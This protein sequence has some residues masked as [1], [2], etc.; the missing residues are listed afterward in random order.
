[1]AA[2]GT[3]DSEWLR[4]L[5]L[6]AEQTLDPTTYR[7]IAQG[8]RE[9]LVAATATAAWRRWRV[10]PESLTA[11]SIATL[12]QEFL[13]TRFASPCAVAPTT[14]QRAVYPEGEVAM[15]HGCRSAGVPMVVS[16]NASAPFEEI[17]ATGVEWWLQAYLPQQRELAEPMV[18]QARACAAK[19]VVLTVDTP[20]V[21][22]KYDGGAMWSAVPSE[23]LRHN[24]GAA[25]QAP[26]A[27]DLGPGDIGWLHRVS[28]LPVVV[29]GVLSPAAARRAIDA[30]AAAIWVSNH[31]G[32]QF[33]RAVATAD[34]L[35]T[36]RDVVPA[37]V[38]L[39]VDGGIS[40]GLD[41]TTALAL[42]ADT[43]FVG[44]LALYALADGGAT[45]VERALRTI[46]T[47]VAESML[48]C[49]VSDVRGARSLTVLRDWSADR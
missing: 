11:V 44:R 7:Y 31:G 28:G 47:E 34:A 46:G 20:V 26:K 25:A 4:D 29:K 18:E 1:M 16:S 48:L 37:D 40:S 38:P 9:G 8:A 27:S 5:A 35:S 2:V 23:W 17:A 6:A 13:G 19:A 10:V 21:G 41:V 43:C 36:I 49:G 15:A 30:G 14:L 22:T 33:D 42:G 3:S 39:F 45:G 32:R 24:L 12:E